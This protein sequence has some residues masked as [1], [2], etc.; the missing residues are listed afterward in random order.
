MKKTIL[1]SLVLAA[2]TMT[3]SA[4]SGTNSPY[5]QYGLGVL[6]DQSQGFN[7]GMNG[8]GIGMRFPDQV[9][10]LNPASYSAVDS[11]T[12][13]FDVGLSGQITNFK[14]G[15]RRINANNANFEYAVG[16][17]R[18]FRNVGVGFGI[19]PFTNIGYDYYTS[20]V[21]NETEIETTT[22]TETYSGSGGVH[23]AFVGLGWRMFKGLSIGVNVGYLWG[24][25]DREIAITSSDSYVNTVTKIYEAD[26]HSYKID[27]G[28][29]YEQPIGKKDRVTLGL[30]Y[31]IGHDLSADP[32]LVTENSNPQTSV[33]YYDTLSIRNGLSVPDMFGA[34]I[35]WTHDN[36]LTIG[37]DYT[38]QKWGELDYP[39]LNVKTGE[40]V[41][42]SGLL[43]DRHKIAL[44]GE[45]V[46]NP[47]GRNFFHRI[48]YRMGVAY[49]T[50]YIKV[51]G[52]DGPKEYSISAGFG[53]PIINAWNNRSML[54]I[55]GQ[56]V[57]AE[58]SGL[59]N[60]NTFRIN[61][62]L[63]FNEKWF[64]KWKVE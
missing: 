34:G 63:T 37:V 62:G 31:T 13:V 56:F 24:S 51:N 17:F 16:S 46:H 58:A 27:F 39:E 15:S 54:N 60:E 33:A 7:R 30:T 47:N 32:E 48:R 14:E 8:V 36:R 40:Y 1:A 23:Q 59:I 20:S 26:I 52:I 10:T 3:A 53:I 45:Y 55:S 18:L 50:P 11:L 28:I 12:M 25:Y 61:I 2:A 64:M 19:L 29:Q 42:K 35:S 6:S 22:S 57:R 21:I 4:Q 44:G 41:M 9:N 38:F 49:N 43:K 5:S